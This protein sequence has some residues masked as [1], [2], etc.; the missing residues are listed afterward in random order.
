[1]NNLN[2]AELQRKLAQSAKTNV[3]FARPIDELRLQQPNKKFQSIQDVI[4]NVQGL[5]EKTMQKIIDAW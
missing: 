1:M 4:I 5:A 3:K 2:F